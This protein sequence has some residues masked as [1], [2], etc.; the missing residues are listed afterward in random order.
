MKGRR[1]K[2]VRNKTPS[3]T[4][5]E[6]EGPGKGSRCGCPRR[7]LHTVPA[8]GV[9]AD[10]RPIGEDGGGKVTKGKG[11]E[12]RPL[13]DPHTVPA[14]GIEADVRPIGEDGGGW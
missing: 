8:V 5:R 10:V 12:I 11:R 3:S 6:D 4:R 2:R 14:V 7:I 9:E 1:R 13:E